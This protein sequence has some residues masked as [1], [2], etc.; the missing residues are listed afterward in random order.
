MGKWLC[1]DFLSYS[2]SV[3]GRK[4]TVGPFHVGPD[5]SRVISL[6]SVFLLVGAVLGSSS[7]YGGRPFPNCPCMG[8]LPLTHTQLGNTLFCLPA[9]LLNHGWGAKNR[10]SDESFRKALFV[11]L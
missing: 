6:F 9:M 4:W 10:G 5:W 7:V 11:L 1:P 2:S 8:V 3:Y